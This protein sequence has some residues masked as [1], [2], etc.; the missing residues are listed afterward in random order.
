MSSDGECEFLLWILGLFGINFFVSQ[1]DFDDD[2]K[3]MV[4]LMTSILFTIVY[5]FLAILCHLFIC[6]RGPTGHL[7]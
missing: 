7:Y 5:C 1:L 2:M 6:A 3:M 4:L